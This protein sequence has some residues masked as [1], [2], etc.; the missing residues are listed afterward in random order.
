MDTGKRKPLHPG[1]TTR[2]RERE[3]ERLTKLLLMKQ[4]T[5][6][7]K[8]ALAPDDPYRGCGV[9]INSC[10]RLDHRIRDAFQLK[11]RTK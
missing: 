4:L 8:A 6:P 11:L 10:Y 2:E 1:I 9:S 3:K 5:C 7:L